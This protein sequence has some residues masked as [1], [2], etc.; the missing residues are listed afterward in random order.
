MEPSASFGDHSHFKTPS[1]KLMIVN[2]ELE[3]PVPCYREPYGGEYPLRLISVPDSHTLNSI[4]LE[5]LIWWQS[6]ALRL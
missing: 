2:K 3:D 1:G 4:F 5:R 6:A